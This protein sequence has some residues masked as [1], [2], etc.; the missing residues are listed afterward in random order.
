MV[1]ATD[2][3]WVLFVIQLG[4]GKKSSSVRLLR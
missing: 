3:H 4:A 2:P 1:K